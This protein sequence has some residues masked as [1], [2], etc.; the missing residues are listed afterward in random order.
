M[1]GFGDKPSGGNAATRVISLVSVDCPVVRSA[2]SRASLNVRSIAFEEGDW[3]RHA[4]GLVAVAAKLLRNDF[5]WLIESGSATD[6][7]L[8]PENG[9]GARTTGDLATPTATLLLESMISRC[10]IRLGR[11]AVETETGFWNL[12]A[13]CLRRLPVEMRGRV[14]LASGA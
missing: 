5:E 4:P 13:E 10:P 3:Q 11:E 9:T 12:A 6:L 7:C 14:S 1:E 2:R 8:P